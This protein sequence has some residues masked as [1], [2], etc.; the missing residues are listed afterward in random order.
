M[1]IYAIGDLHLSFSCEKPMDVFG[2]QW[3]D[4]AKRLDEAWRAVVG[5]EDLVLIPGDIS[6]AMQLSAAQ[7]DLDFIGALPGKKLLLRGNH[8]YWWSSLTRVRAALDPSVFA[9]QN[10]AFVYGAYAIGGTRGWNCPGSAGFTAADEKIHAR[11]AQ[12]LALSLAQLPE[13]KIRIVM[14]HFP[15]FTERGFD[16]TFTKLFAQYGVSRVVYAHLHGAAHKHAFEGV[17]E[18]VRYFF[19]AGDYLQFVPT[20]IE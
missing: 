4:H 3:K 15:P 12:R 6:W 9:L 19:A 11:E 14:M 5:P 8:D 20:R 1:H 18:N 17:H 2:P 7:P 13:H 10:D 16:P